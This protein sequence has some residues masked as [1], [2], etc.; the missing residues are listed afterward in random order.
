MPGDK[1]RIAGIEISFE[2]YQFFQRGVRMG[3][4]GN[5]IQEALREAGIGLRRE[6][7]QTI[8][9]EL[10]DREKKRDAWKYTPHKFV[11]SDEAHEKA[12]TKLKT[13]YSYTVR[14]E[15][16]SEITGTTIERWVRLNSD[17]RMS[18]NEILRYAEEALEDAGVS[19]TYRESIKTKE[20]YRLLRR[21]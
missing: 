18:R 13:K 2:Q 16:E 19:E 15:M 7:A 21:N 4:S 3:L 11:P 10:T 1:I 14:F 5:R 20:L 6:R 9:R 17:R 8:Y 12:L